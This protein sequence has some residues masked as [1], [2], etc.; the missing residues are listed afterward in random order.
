MHKCF[1]A[2]VTMGGVN[3]CCAC[4]LLD[5]SPDCQQDGR[6][7]LSL[8]ETS[9]AECSTVSACHDMT[10]YPVKQPGDCSRSWSGKLA[11]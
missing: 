1:D 6:P 2:A 5:H 3:Q 9:R 11:T 8:Q 4:V 10:P 7:L